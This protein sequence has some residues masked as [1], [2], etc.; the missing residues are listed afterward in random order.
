MFLLYSFPSSSL[1][2]SDGRAGDSV[3]YREAPACK[4]YILCHLPSNLI[5]FCANEGINVVI[6]YPLHVS[7]LVC[8]KYSFLFFLSCSLVTFEHHLNRSHIP[9][10][11]LFHYNSLF[12]PSKS[13]KYPRTKYF[14]EQAL[15]VTNHFSVR[16]LSLLAFLVC[17]LPPSL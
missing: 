12:W 5:F 14:E 6:L 13:S 3:Q 15:E 11:S 10:V 1:L 17:F 7:S 16:V 8:H 4:L 2:E 9:Y